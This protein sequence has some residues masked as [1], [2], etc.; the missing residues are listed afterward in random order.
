MYGR[1]QPL[2][3]LLLL[4]WHKIHAEPQNINKHR[5][6]L[7]LIQN[8]WTVW[9]EQGSTQTCV[10]R[11]G[12][13]FGGHGGRGRGEKVTWEGEERC[14][15]NFVWLLIHFVS[16]LSLYVLATVR[17]FTPR[18]PECGLKRSPK[19][20]AGENLSEHRIFFSKMGS[21]AL[22]QGVENFGWDLHFRGCRVSPLES[23]C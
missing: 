16:M 7:F 2:K 6:D 22:R 17:I 21:Q 11:A 19:E 23:Q 20:S 8:G 12:G 18:L 15:D 1:R 4:Q 14:T 5:S 9:T 13:I 3:F 10:L